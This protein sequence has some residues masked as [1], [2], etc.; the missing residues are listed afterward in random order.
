MRTVQS[1]STILSKAGMQFNKDFIIDCIIRSYYLDNEIATVH[2]LLEDANFMTIYNATLEQFNIVKNEMDNSKNKLEMMEFIKSQINDVNV[3]IMS[4]D[5]K[6]SDNKNKLIEIRNDLVSIQEL[7]NALKLVI[8]KKQEYDNI[9]NKLSDANSKIFTVQSS[10]KIIQDN[11]SEIERLSVQLDSVNK[12]IKPMIDDRDTLRH[13]LKLLEGYLAEYDQYLSKFNTI[14]LLK[15]YSSPYK[16]IGIVYMALYLN[17]TLTIANDLLNLVFDGKYCLAPF[18][19]DEND[20]KIPCMGNSIMNDDIASMSGGEIAI[21]S[22]IISFSILHQS[23]TQYNIFK[24]DEM[25]APLDSINRSLFVTVL[26]RMIEILQLD[27][28]IIISHNEEIPMNS[29]D[30]IIL[31]T[32]KEYEGNIIYKYAQ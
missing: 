27:Q 11:L 28:V 20:F 14:E 2:K 10:M 18:V 12:E 16:G 25:D 5:K 6:L 21:I 30:V 23:A 7:Q 3:G 9:E 17:S 32:D 29:T 4:I 1:C 15:K 26:Y 31:K 22:M 8:N 13:S 19:I 24:L